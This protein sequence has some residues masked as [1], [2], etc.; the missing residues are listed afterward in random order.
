MTHR[1]H[2]HRAGVLNFWYYDEAEFYFADGRLILRGSNGSGKSVTMQSF[3][4]LVLD[5]DKRPWRLDPFGSRDRKIE[6]YLLLDGEHQERTAYLWLEFRLPEPERFLTIGIG[7]RARQTVHAASFWGFS[8]E[9]NRRIGVDLFLYRR[10]YSGSEEVKVPLSR[11]QLE[12]AIGDGGRVVSSTG[13]Y[14]RLVNQLLFGFEDETAY[15]E[16]LDLLIQ[17][18]SPKLSKDFKPT[19]IYDILTSALP[20][21]EENDLRPLSEVLEDMDEI[22][23]RLDEL[24]VHRKEAQK[25]AEAYQKYN[26]YQLFVAAQAV[27]QAHKVWKK[28]ELERE[29]QE[30]RLVALEQQKAELEQEEER[31]RIR[32]QQLEREQDV[33]THHEAIGKEKELERL[34][35]D[36]ASKEGLLAQ[37]E[38]R[39]GNNEKH[40]AEWTSLQAQAARQSE[41]LVLAQTQDIEELNDLAHAIAFPYSSSYHDL[42]EQ[43]IPER[44]QVNWTAWRNDLEEH[45]QEVKA[46]LRLAREVSR[47][48]ET[49]KELEYELGETSRKRDAQER[50]VTEKE[51]ELYD[52]LE[53]QQNRLFQWREQVN[54]LTLTDRQF[55]E[56]LH[57]LSQF[58]DVSYERVREPLAEAY[59]QALRRLLQEAAQLE[60]NEKRHREK[61]DELQAEWLDWRDRKEPEPPATEARRTS[62]ARR[63]AAGEG[64]APLY[65]VCAFYDHVGEAERARLE[66]LLERSG[67]LDAWVSPAGTLS[68]RDGEEDVWLVPNPQWLAHTLADWLYPTPPEDSHLTSEQIDNVLRTI[69]VGTEEVPETG[70]A[71][72]PSGAFRLGPL[73]GKAR[74]KE[75]AEYIGKETREQTRMRE[76]KRLEDA[77]AEEQEALQKCREQIARCKEARQRLDEEREAF[78]AD[79]ELQ[80]KALAWQDARRELTYAQELVRRADQKYQQAADGLRKLRSELLEKVRKRSLPAREN[81]LER[82]HEQVRLYERVLGSLQRSW[83]DYWNEQDKWRRAADEAE[84]LRVQLEEE[85]ANWLEVKGELNVL[86]H[87]IGTVERLLDELGLLDI[88]RRLA[89]LRQSIQQIHVAKEKRERAFRELARQLGEASNQAQQQREQAEAAA[90]RLTVVIASYVREWKRGLVS[91]FREA[92]L[93]A[94]DQEAIVAHCRTVTRALR[95][96]YA[97]LTQEQ[98]S[99]RVLEAFNSTRQ[100]L[101]DYVPEAEL[102]DRIIIQFCRD[103]QH[104]QSPES[105]LLEL[106]E[107]EREQELLLK[108][109]DREL[110]EQVLIHSVGRAIREKIY[111]AEAWVERMN[112]LMKRRK[113]SSGLRLRLRWEPRPAQNEEEMDTAELV[114]LLRTDAG[115][116]REE[117]FERMVTHFRS[118]VNWARREAEERDTLREWI[119]RILDYRHWFRFTLYYE[120]GG[121]SWKELTDA[122]FNVLSGGEKAMAMYIPLFAATYSRYMSS[123]EQSPKIIC[124]DEAFAGV[125][126]ANLRDMFELLTDMGFDYMMTSQVLWGCYDTVPNLSIYELLRPQDADFVTL[127]RFH[128]DGKRRRMI[129]QEDWKE[130][131]LEA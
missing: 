105:L 124:L 72:D 16:L 96:A 102:G 20:A 54:E 15:Q 73:Y 127:I 99:N 85:E 9:D 26:D 118:R 64:G 32:L 87:E 12:E 53:T 69:V 28:E 23:D 30:E 6:Y 131:L 109:K 80:A 68:V 17:L 36:Y 111:R 112:D 117:Q 119:Y 4:P 70:V 91:A 121:H 130:E 34:K 35:S 42:W 110:Y 65:A 47:Q 94:D 5:G 41:A 33:L 60:E 114:K 92:D 14:K 18:R 101:H 46:A 7:L 24:R 67:L 71:V 57:R 19:T 106:S 86:R 79:D 74:S 125:D 1:W 97:N 44:E 56:M 107:Q 39:R 126:E 83:E 10:D 55:Q 108:E 48:E 104:P 13:E 116:L 88:H 52:S 49:V 38:R 82:V 3:L 113:T 76:M 40:L 128:W 123:R 120:K 8:V 95:D 115:L 25:L 84:R 75:R 100:V 78:P 61:Y 90:H 43:D 22:S 122:R 21:L 45:E 103:R 37:I 29:Q 66:E 58:P 129:G 89:E 81:E 2:L 27:E 51:R 50:L 11:S 59:E 62:R 77:M 93:P 31:E 63:Q 98:L